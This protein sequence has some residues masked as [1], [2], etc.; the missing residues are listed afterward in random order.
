MRLVPGSLGGYED[1]VVDVYGVR[2]ALMP[3]HILLRAVPH[4]EEELGLGAAQGA[5]REKGEDDVD[6]HVDVEKAL[7]YIFKISFLFS[8][9]SS[10]TSSNSPPPSLG[11][12]ARTSRPSKGN[13]LSARVYRWADGDNCAAAERAKWRRNTVGAVRDASPSSPAP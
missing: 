5:Q 11:P 7:I 6:V 10:Q 4:A 8:S 2:G 1:P 13:T 3:Q 12:S 9:R